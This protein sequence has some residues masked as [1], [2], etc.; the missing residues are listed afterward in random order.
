MRRALGSRIK[1]ILN[2]PDKHSVATCPPVQ[3]PSN[4]RAA[5]RYSVLMN[6]KTPQHTPSG[7]HS[8]DAVSRLVIPTAQL[9]RLLQSHGITNEKKRVSVVA[10]HS[11]EL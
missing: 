4:A 2:A 7:L 6:H 11:S 1:N 3:L 9:H 5:S 8:P 10:Y